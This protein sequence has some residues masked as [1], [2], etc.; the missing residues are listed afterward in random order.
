MEAPCMD[1]S[2]WTRIKKEKVVKI[3]DTIQE[4]PVRKRNT[5]PTELDS[6]KIVQEKDSTNEI[7]ELESNATKEHSQAYWKQREEIEKELPTEIKDFADVFCSE[8]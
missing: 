4:E 8:D 2:E 6:R 7:K 5:K 1:Y 3:P